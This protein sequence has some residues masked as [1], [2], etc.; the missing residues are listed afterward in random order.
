M[1][2]KVDTLGNIYSS[3]PGGIWIVA[4][5][6]SSAMKAY[7]SS[8]MTWLTITG[9]VLTLIGGAAANGLT[10]LNPP[11]RLSATTI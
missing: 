3:G 6:F 4:P 1:G 5:G 11:N 8:R 9:L 7:E 10:F 2:M